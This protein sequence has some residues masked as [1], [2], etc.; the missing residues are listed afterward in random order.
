MEKRPLVANDIVPVLHF[1]Q[2]WHRGLHRFLEFPKKKC[3]LNP[4]GMTDLR[5]FRKI[6]GDHMSVMG[7]VPSTLSAIG[8]PEQIRN[9]VRDLV[10]DI[11][12]Q[13]LLIAPGCDVPVNTKPENMK[14]FSAAAH[15]FGK[16]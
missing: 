5:K 8:S 10:R 11:G 2:C 14:A 9:Y 12:P 3:V 6:V 7:D 1:D 16:G 15:E 13:G 4:D